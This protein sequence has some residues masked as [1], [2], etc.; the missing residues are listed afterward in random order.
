MPLLDVLMSLSD[1]NLWKS[2]AVNPHGVRVAKS[3][4]FQNAPEPSDKFG[5]RVQPIL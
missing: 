1:G 3:G 2:A 4:R 5:P